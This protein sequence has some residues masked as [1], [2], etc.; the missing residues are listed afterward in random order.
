MKEVSNQPANLKKVDTYKILMVG[1]FIDWKRHL[2]LIQAVESLIS[3]RYNI[4]LTLVGECTSD[5]Q[6]K[7]LERIREY[8]SRQ[9]L[10]QNISIITNVD[11]NSMG[12]FYQNAHFFVLPS[13]GEVFGFSSLEALSHGLP[14][15]VSTRNGFQYNITNGYNGYVFKADNIIDLISKIKLLTNFYDLSIM[16]VNCLQYVKEHHSPNIYIDNI[17]NLI[18]VGYKD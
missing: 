5:D 3:E 11:H 12:I 7:Y 17:Y 8:V 4:Q 18:S 10:D 14:V 13:V 16:Q 6:M 1:K 9:K 2:F 15:I